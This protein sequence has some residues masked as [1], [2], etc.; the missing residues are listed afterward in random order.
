MT[1]KFRKITKTI[2]LASETEE[3]EYK[4]NA[5][6]LD[7]ISNGV[8]LRIFDLLPLSD[9]FWNVGYVCQELYDISF[10]YINVIE[11]PYIKPNQ[12][13]SQEVKKVFETYINQF[14]EDMLIA[15]SIRYVVVG[16]EKDKKELLEEYQTT[17]DYQTKTILFCQEDLYRM[18]WFGRYFIFLTSRCLYMEKLHLLDNLG[19]EIVKHVLTDGGKYIVEL[20]LDGCK[21]T[22]Q[23]LKKI[24]DPLNQGGPLDGRKQL[25]NF[26]L[27]CSSVTDHGLKIL[28]VNCIDLRELYL[29]NCSFLTSE[30]LK[31]IAN[32]CTDLQTLHLSYA[33]QFR[34]KDVMNI[35]E[36]FNGLHRVINKTRLTNLSLSM[37]RSITDEA[38]LSI[39][40]HLQFLVSLNLCGTWE[41]SDSG[42]QGVT[43]KCR[44]LRILDLSGCWELTDKSMK[45]ISENCPNLERLNVSGCGCVSDFGI[46]FIATSCNQLKQLGLSACIGITNKGFQMITD[47]CKFLVVLDLSGS[48][49]MT[50]DGALHIVN[51]SCSLTLLDLRR[52]EKLTDECVEMLRRKKV[53]LKVL[54]ARANV[55][56]LPSTDKNTKN[57]KSNKR[58][59]KS[60]VSRK[61]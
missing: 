60:R 3:N 59:Q 34:N 26:K 18:P 31:E 55:L 7:L 17:S 19:D 6:L 1:R 15:E 25:I 10:R 57:I 40:Y 14:T 5:T 32:N 54:F 11:F 37:C 56:N 35:A 23:G 27:D 45:S 36:Q 16:K 8:I 47:F 58:V 48:H 53:G 51:N 39:G 12:K 28:A 20:D 49:N 41:L 2:I 52:C 43:D 44:R 33:K 50:D 9:V 42:I 29:I 38:I 13:D 21:L 30:G 24:T 46:D 22:D 4:G 61:K